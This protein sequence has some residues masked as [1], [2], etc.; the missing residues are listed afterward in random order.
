M[1]LVTFSPLSVAEME[2]LAS[3]YFS[4]IPNKEADKPVVTTELN[5]AEAA[6]N[7]L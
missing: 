4:L 2:A 1:A 5:F 6:I 3:G 7:S